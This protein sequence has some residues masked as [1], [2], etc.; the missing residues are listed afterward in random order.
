VFPA[1]I[2][3]VFIATSPLFLFISI[4]SALPINRGQFAPLLVCF[5]CLLA[6]FCYFHSAT[7]STN[8]NFA[9]RCAGSPAINAFSHFSISKKHKEF[10]LMVQPQPMELWTSLQMVELANSQLVTPAADFNNLTTENDSLVNN[11][12]RRSFSI[13][14]ITWEW[15][16][17]PGFTLQLLNINFPII[18][19]VYKPILIKVNNW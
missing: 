3:Q 15:L 7:N 4:L 11:W 18:S 16:Q 19:M 8:F 12:P 2:L 9:L 13:F 17:L 5:G 1:H 6:N 14:I 10:N